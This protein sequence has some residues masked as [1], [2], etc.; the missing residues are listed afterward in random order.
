MST[1]R[2]RERS[3]E[4]DSRR[5]RD[6]SRD[7]DSRRRRSRSRSRDRRRRSPERRRRSPERRGRSGGRNQHDDRGRGGRGRSPEET[8][9]Q[10][11][12]KDMEASLTTEQRAALD[13]DRDQRT[14]FVYQLSVKATEEDVFSLFENAGTVHDVRLIT[15]RNT[16]K[17]KG[18]GY[19]EFENRDSI[20]RA[21]ALSGTIM[22]G[23]PVM[24]KFSEA[25]KN[26]AAQQA[27]AAAA[28]VGPMKLYVGNLHVD[29]AE[30]DIRALFSPFGEVDSVQIHKD[31]N[32]A[33]GFG[34][35][36]FKDAEEG[37]MALGQLNGF[38]VAGMNIKVGLVSDPEEGGQSLNDTD[39]FNVN[40]QSRAQ[41]MA[42]LQSGG[43]DP[44][45]LLGQMGAMGAP[46]MGAQ[47]PMGAP[48]MGAHPPTGAPPMPPSAP[49]GAVPPAGLNSDPGVQVL[50]LI[51]I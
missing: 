51:H 45:A 30:G 33:V 6:R 31:P 27:N 37:R 19:I 26:L 17:S 35:V 3:R 21:I 43:L 24:V 7:R 38:E 12:R 2:S 20:P 22:R 16:R 29:V 50:S 48:P 23:I 47:P 4:R 42:R 49:A 18:F 14:V 11:K 39:E 15:D 32:G 9:E 8:E 13:A 44:T 5:R 34:F 41:L 46:M 25:E 10:R 28:N 40:N 36:N 1:S